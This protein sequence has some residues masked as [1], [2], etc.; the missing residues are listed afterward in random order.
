MADSNLKGWI[1]FLI[2]VIIVIGG[3]FGT[4]HII[5]SASS[6]VSITS[7]GSNVTTASDYN[8]TSSILNVSVSPSTL[9]INVTVN[10]TTTSPGGVVNYTVVS[11]SILNQSRYDIFYNASYAALFHKYSQNFNST[12]NKTYNG[13][14]AYNLSK[15]YASNLSDIQA[16]ASSNASA[17]AYS[18]STYS[19]ITPFTSTI[20]EKAKSSKGQ[21]SFNLNLNYTAVSLMKKGQERFIKIDL[22]KGATGFIGYLELYRS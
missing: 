7:I 2:V 1:G 12:Y 18:N 9:D 6:A 19:F 20:S 22:Y 15:A 13:T 11:P 5:K 21:I 14:P 3:A 4:S 17:E 8:A 10:F 16:N